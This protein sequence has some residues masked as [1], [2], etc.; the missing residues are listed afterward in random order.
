LLTNNQATL[1]TLDAGYFGRGVY[2]S[3]NILYTLPYAF[4]K[5]NPALIISYLNPGNVFPV[6]EDHK[7]S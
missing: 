2:F 3:S 5:R 6:T 4:S 1:S 7:G